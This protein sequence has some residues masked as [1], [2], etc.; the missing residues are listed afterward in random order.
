MED[1]LREAVAN[2]H[3]DYTEARWEQVQ[4]SRVAFQRDQLMALDSGEEAGG[5]VRCLV[6]GAWGLAVFTDP[7]DLRRKIEEATH[8]ARTASGHVK[9]PVALAPVKAVVARHEGKMNRDFRGVPLD[10]KRRLAEGYNKLL[11]GHS[12]EIAST[13]VR[14]TDAWRKVIF[15]NSEGTYVEQGIPDVTLML[16]AVARRNGDIQQ[17]FESLG[18]AAGF[19]AIQGKEEEAHKAA[20]RAVDLLSAQS[21]RGG[22]YTV[23]LD[24]DLAG[25]FIHEAFGHI[26]EADFLLKNEPMRKVMQVGTKFGVEAL[27]VVDDGYRPGER[28]NAP[29]DDEG[30]PWQKAYLIRKGVLTGLMHSRATA[31]KL[32][33]EPTGNARAVSWEHE[34]IVRMRNTYIEP[35][36]ATLDE[37]LQG[38]EHGLYACAAFG[39]QTMFE[40]F[41]FSAGW[42]HEIVNGK[43]GPMVRDVVLTGNVFHT[44]Q[45]V[46]MIGRDFRLEGSSGGCGKGGQWP[47]P[48][49]T[50]APHVR[51]RNVTVGGR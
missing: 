45:N 11:L 30:V 35:G 16:A 36:T 13:T 18:Y 37:M 44:L 15:A 51:V 38:I 23:I 46:E 5:I 28:G 8:L 27:T 43:I 9:D 1:K 22:T 39:G 19:D 29:Y 26:C 33:A 20:R 50:G 41:T 24:P 40:Q 12:K 49:T 3:A 34:P 17:G 48:T 4:R 25:V 6:R 31:H 14:Y 7:A 10:E 21:V 42:G 32:K 47:L 2:S